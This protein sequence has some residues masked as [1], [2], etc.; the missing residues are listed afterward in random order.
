MILNEMEKI[1]NLW[2]WVELLTDEQCQFS[3]SSFFSPTTEVTIYS[4]TFERENM[5]EVA[6]PSHGGTIP[7]WHL[8]VMQEWKELGYFGDGDHILW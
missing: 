7:L 6:A 2:N 3:G 4:R 5:W 1:Y 8:K